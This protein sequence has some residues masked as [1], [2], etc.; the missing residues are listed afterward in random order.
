MPASSAIQRILGLWYAIIAFINVTSLA[1]GYE[2][3][4]PGDLSRTLIFVGMDGTRF[5]YPDLRPGV[6]PFGVRGPSV[7]GSLTGPGLMGHS[8]ST[9]PVFSP[10][11]TLR[12][13]APPQ[14]YPSTLSPLSSLLGSFDSC[15]LSTV[16]QVDDSQCTVVL[17]WEGGLQSLWLVFYVTLSY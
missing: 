5:P 14:Q 17:D 8:L 2:L 11:P 4:G 16:A 1:K 13:T 6:V 12:G 7:Q 15:E 3:Q 10:V 9:S